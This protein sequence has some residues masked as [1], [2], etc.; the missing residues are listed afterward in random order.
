MVG[1]VYETLRVAVFSVAMSGN[2]AFLP[3]LP[4]E[5]VVPSG[6]GEG[7]VIIGLGLANASAA[8]TY[9]FEIRAVNN[10]GTVQSSKTLSIVL[11]TGE[12]YKSARLPTPFKV[13]VGQHVQVAVTSAP[14]GATATLAVFWLTHVIQLPEQRQVIG[15]GSV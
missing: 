5:A 12:A 4:P 1:D 2:V 8:G 7:Y 10:A 14:T 6:E 9:S 3:A 15:T 13:P 11:N